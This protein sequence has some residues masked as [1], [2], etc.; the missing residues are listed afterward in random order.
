MGKGIDKVTLK[1]FDHSAKGSWSVLTGTMVDGRTV[2]VPKSPKERLLPIVHPFCL[3]SNF[4]GTDD[5]I[6]EVIS[7]QGCKREEYS[8]S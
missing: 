1:S 3:F 8:I 7:E 5:C 2:S 4:L 6:C